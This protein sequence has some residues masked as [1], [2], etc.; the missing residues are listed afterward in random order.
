MPENREQLYADTVDLLIDAWERP[1][2][3][4]DSKGAPLIIQPSL[5]EWLKIDRIQMRRVFNELAYNAHT[6]QLE[7][8][9]TARD[10]DSGAA[11]GFFSLLQRIQEFW[12]T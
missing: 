1:K 8:T 7:L 11:M 12:E 9:G 2:V 6:R 5:M 3:V 4:K 10:G